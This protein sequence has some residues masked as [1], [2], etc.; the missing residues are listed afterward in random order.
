MDWPQKHCDDKG[1]EF[2]SSP[3]SLK[4]VDLL[5]K[6]GVNRYKLGSGRN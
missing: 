4:A 5:E 1:L 2:I 6:I 3:F